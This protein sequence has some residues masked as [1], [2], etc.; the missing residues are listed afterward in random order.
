VLERQRSVRGS[1]N[2]T[3]AAAGFSSLTG[4][5]QQQQQQQQQAAAP[6]A[7]TYMSGSSGSGEGV[8]RSERASLI[9]AV[10]QRQQSRRSA[11]AAAAAGA[12]LGLLSAANS[13][14]DVAAAWPAGFSV[15]AAAVGGS[16]AGSTAAVGV[17]S[18]AW[19]VGAGATGGMFGGEGGVSRAGSLAP[20]GA[21]RASIVA[22]VLA[23]RASTAAGG[24][25]PQQQVPSVARASGGSFAPGADSRGVS[26]V[27]G[28]GRKDRA[29]IVAAVLAK[30]KLASKH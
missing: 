25:D 17:E 13:S 2:S 3:T 23:K 22:A 5:Q 12:P 26:P 10:L 9:S 27:G 15:G 7:Y 16:G 14:T 20:P 18:S 29:A 19:S 6:D 30:H 28:E 1:S 8:I 11:L 24:Q 4:A 21:D